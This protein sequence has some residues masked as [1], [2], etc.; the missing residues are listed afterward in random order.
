MS[1]QPAGRQMTYDELLA[2]LKQMSGELQAS[3]R[4]HGEALAL[5]R[6]KYERERISLVSALKS[7]AYSIEESQ[8]GYEHACVTEAH[9]AL[10]EAGEDV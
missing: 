2:A 4:R 9:K 5:Q 1:E 10:H 8:E 3:E 7:C 6:R